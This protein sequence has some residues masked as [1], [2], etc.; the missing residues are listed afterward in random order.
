MMNKLLETGMVLKLL[1][2]KYKLRRK[3]RIQFMKEC[4]GYS[5]DIYITCCNSVR[6]GLSWKNERRYSICFEYEAYG[7]LLLQRLC[8]SLFPFLFCNIL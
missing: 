1:V 5:G 3:E 8:N 4:R 6:G 2:A 7:M